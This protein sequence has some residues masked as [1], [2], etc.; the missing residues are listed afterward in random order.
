MLKIFYEASINILWE[1]IVNVFSVFLQLAAF[2]AFAICVNFVGPEGV[3]TPYNTPY[4]N[5]LALF[6]DRNACW[7]IFAQ[8]FLLK[9][10]SEN[11]GKAT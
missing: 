5:P 11:S 4:P 9:L 3:H 10:E 6:S 1:E 2:C 8:F 7:A